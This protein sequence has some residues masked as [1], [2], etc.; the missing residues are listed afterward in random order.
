MVDSADR[1]IEGKR[2]QAETS[3]RSSKTRKRMK[4]SYRRVR[5]GIARQLEKKINT[6]RAQ[7]KKPE[8]LKQR[9]RY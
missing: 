2:I 3:C 7:G 5:E 8:L 4:K 6:E 1:A 9:C